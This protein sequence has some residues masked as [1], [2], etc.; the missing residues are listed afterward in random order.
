M[1][2][3]KLN[4]FLIYIIIINF[5]CLFNK[6]FLNLCALEINNYE[7]DYNLKY[8]AVN[9]RHE[10]G[11]MFSEKAHVF[12]K[13]FPMKMFP[14]KTYQEFAN[15]KQIIKNATILTSNLLFPFNRIFKILDTIQE[16]ASDKYIHDSDDKIAFINELLKY[17][18]KYYP[19]KGIFFFDLDQ[20]N[21]ID[22]VNITFCNCD[23]SESLCSV[24]H[25]LFK[26]FLQDEVEKIP[27]IEI[28]MNE[29][30]ELE[31]SELN[32]DI[33]NFCRQTIQNDSVIRNKIK[34]IIMKKIQDNIGRQITK[35]CFSQTTKLISSKLIGN[36]LLPGIVESCEM[37]KQ[38]QDSTKNIQKNIRLYLKNYNFEKT[39]GFA[40]DYNNLTNQ[41]EVFSL[42]QKG[43]ST[44]LY[45]NFIDKINILDSTHMLI[46]FLQPKIKGKPNMNLNIYGSKVKVNL[47]SND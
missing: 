43:L 9:W 13:I 24:S 4:K 19:E 16:V 40:F 45:A 1:K 18:I 47:N 2:L 32:L 20:L 22:Y 17:L 46:S 37:I 10:N 28:F 36:L 3:L 11:H 14:C 33:K 38:N 30:S 39:L 6:D 15:T 29:A 21:E 35:T 25:E 12:Y 44:G 31:I 8:Y 7:K 27:Y 42:E 5:I 26:N 41:L 23:M 34:Q